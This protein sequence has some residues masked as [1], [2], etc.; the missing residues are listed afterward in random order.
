M[1]SSTSTFTL[2]Q[3]CSPALA[4]LQFF[5]QDDKHPQCSIIA[6]AELASSKIGCFTYRKFV[7]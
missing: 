4:H 5:T 2:A 3:R 1:T 6:H 7:S